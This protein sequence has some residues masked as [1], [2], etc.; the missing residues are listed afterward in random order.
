[1][2][3]VRLRLQEASMT[4]SETTLKTGLKMLYA[5]GIEFAALSYKYN[6]PGRTADVVEIVERELQRCAELVDDEI[7]QLRRAGETNP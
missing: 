6:Q 5:A 2:L 3:L 7:K 4:V 1:V